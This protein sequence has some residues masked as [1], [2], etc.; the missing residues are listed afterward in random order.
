M[1][2]PVCQPHEK[3]LVQCFV[4]FKK[5]LYWFPLDEGL[6]GGK[7]N[8]SPWQCNSILRLPSTLLKNGWP[9]RNGGLSVYEYTYSKTPL[10]I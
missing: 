7:K 10:I 5:Q 8:L 6:E 9:L 1:P 4:F 2:H 3:W